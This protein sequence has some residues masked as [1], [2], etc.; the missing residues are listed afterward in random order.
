MQGMKQKVPFSTAVMTDSTYTSII[1]VECSCSNICRILEKIQTLR[2]MVNDHHLRQLWAQNFFLPVHWSPT[3]CAQ[4]ATDF[5]CELMDGAAAY[6]FACSASSKTECPRDT[7]MSKNTDMAVTYTRQLV[8]FRYLRKDLIRR[9][10][11]LEKSRAGLG[12][13]QVLFGHVL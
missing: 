1:T 6:P 11:R 12:L 13:I 9:W 2:N 4:T 7:Q 10:N 5:S 8:I 3:L